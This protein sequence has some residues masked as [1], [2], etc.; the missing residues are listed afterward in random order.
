MHLVFC[1]TAL[2]LGVHSESVTVTGYLIPNLCLSAENGFLAA[3]GT[4]VSSN[5]EQHSVKCA[6]LTSPPCRQSGYAMVTNAAA[7]GQTPFFRSRYVLDGP[8]NAIAV[9]FLES[10]DTRR[11]NCLVTVKGLV[12]NGTLLSL[13]A[14]I[15]DEGYKRDSAAA[16]ATTAASALAALFVFLLL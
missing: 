13:E 8:S 9:T 15:K 6:L 12:G 14:S 10:L 7:A 5:P 4:N 3:D 1:L 2:F 16:R 11:V